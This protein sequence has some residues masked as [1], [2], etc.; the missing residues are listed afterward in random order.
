[1]NVSSGSRPA[2]VMIFF[3]MRSTCV[4]ISPL[5]PHGSPHAP[6]AVFMARLTVVRRST[7]LLID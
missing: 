3:E 6:R 2:A 4:S 7:S 5:P 1:M